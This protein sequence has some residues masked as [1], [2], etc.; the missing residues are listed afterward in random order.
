MADPKDLATQ[1]SA[2]NAIEAEQPWYK[3][4]LPMEGRATFLPF[5]D[6]MEGSVFNK[7]ELALPGI[8]AGALNAFTSPERAR[9]SSD[10]TFNA[11]EEAAN[12][13]QN[14]MG[15]GVSTSAAMK[16][17]MGQGGK[18]LA[19]NAW[20][21]TPHEIQGKFSLEKI[22]TGEG[23][24]SY[25]HG[26]Y[27]AENPAVAKEYQQK[28]SGYINNSK[29]ALSRAG[30]DY[31]LA[32]ADAIKSREHYKTHP[33]SENDKPMAARMLKIAEKKIE[34]LNAMKQGIPESKGNLYKVDIPDEHIP[35]MIDFDKHLTEQS[36]QVK[37]ILENYQKELGTSFGTGEQILKEIA[38][39]RRMKGLD[40]SPAAVSK[41]LNDLGITGIQYLDERSRGNFKAYTTYKDKQYGDVI[42]FKT[43]KQLDDYIKEKELEGFGVKTIPPT[44]NFVSFNP[45][46][47]N[48]LEKNGQPTRKELLKQEF[49]KLEK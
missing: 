21:G 29:S 16:A 26:I 11:G 8:L 15:G 1:L 48:I 47:V 46:A 22:G 30:G 17:P 34:E 42:D 36:P 27:F 5:R 44:R 38:F 9:T 6:T 20:H 25:G 3:K 2:F 24:Q 41:Q 43:K 7:R 4:Q 10:P 35:Y 32:I 45:E 39:D 14:V 31:D 37:K 23:A 49:D 19:L 18:D 28:L 40:D 13:A 12:F 33:F